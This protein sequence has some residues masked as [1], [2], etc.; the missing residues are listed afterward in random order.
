MSGWRGL[1]VLGV[2]CGATL[3]PVGRA[4]ASADLRLDKDFI[5]GIIEKFPAATFE[6]QGQ[7][8]GTV[9]GFRLL[10]IEPRTR[11]LVVACRIEGE[12]RAPVNGPITD[13]VARSREIPQGWR[14]FS[15]DIKARVNIEPGGDAAP[16][17]RIGIDEVKRRELDGFSGLLAKVLGQFFDDLITQI[18]NGRADSATAS[19]P[20]SPDASACSR[21]TGSSA[22]SSIRR[23]R[24]SSIST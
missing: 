14:K 1:V 9:H 5:A 21:N 23:P 18:A 20:R 11:Q 4:E 10:A 19:T 6:Q 15:F 24:S 7:I 13:R 16:R 17:F 12:F 8:R 22:G 2:L 3:M